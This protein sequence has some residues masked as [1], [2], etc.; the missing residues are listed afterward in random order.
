MR[1]QTNEETLKSSIDLSLVDNNFNKDDAF[2]SAM[3][4]TIKRLLNV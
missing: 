1:S 4:D 2:K 3:Q